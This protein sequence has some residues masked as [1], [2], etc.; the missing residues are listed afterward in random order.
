[1]VAYSTFVEDCLSGGGLSV[2]SGR[3]EVGS[4]FEVC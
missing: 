2:L 4:L 3:G 1:M